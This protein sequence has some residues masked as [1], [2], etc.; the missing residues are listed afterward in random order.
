METITINGH[1][2]YDPP[3]EMSIIAP[4]KSAAV[5]ETYGGAAYF[6]WGLIYPGTNIIL[7]WKYMLASDWNTIQSFMPLLGSLYFTAKT[8]A[9]PGTSPVFTVWLMSLTGMYH[10]TMQTGTNVYRKNCTLN[11]VI[12]SQVS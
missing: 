2:I 9:S 7:N 4:N 3:E 11:L 6:N 10:R 5:I 12:E 8:V 1:V